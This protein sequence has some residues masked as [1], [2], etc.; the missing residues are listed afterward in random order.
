MNYGYAPVNGDIDAP[1]LAPSDEPD[2]LCIQLYL[3]AIDQSDLRDKDV[4]EV[5]SGRGGGASYISRCLQPRT[6]TGM[7]FSQAAME[8]CHRH[9]GASGCVVR[10]W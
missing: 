3:H 8:L 1:S 5:G 9:H 6:M 2:R 10:V 7:D 4:L